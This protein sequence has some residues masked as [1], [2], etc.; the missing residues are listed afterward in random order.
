MSVLAIEWVLSGETEYWKLAR[1]MDSLAWLIAYK[2]QDFSLREGLTEFPDDGIS[3][4]ISVPISV[5]G[6]KWWNKCR[7]G[8][9]MAIMRRVG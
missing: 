7:D 9:E 6:I 2:L 5:L 1:T 8:V 3:G 4:R